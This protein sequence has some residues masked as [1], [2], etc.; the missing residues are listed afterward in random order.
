MISLEKR[1][2]VMRLMETVG[3][4]LRES[5]RYRTDLEAMTLAELRVELKRV[6]VETVK[7]KTR[8]AK[9]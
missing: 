1:R 8:K 6:E 7:P 2:L 3:W 5:R 9:L 4:S